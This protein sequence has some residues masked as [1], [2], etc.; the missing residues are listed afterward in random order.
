MQDAEDVYEYSSDS[1]VPEYLLWR[2]HTSL[3]ESRRYVHL[4]KKYYA[5]KEFFDWALEHKESGKM[6]GTCGFSRID[7]TNSCAE[8]GYV[9]NRD[10]W[11][12]GLAVEAAREVIRIGFEILSFNRIEARYMVENQASAR[13]L[14]KLG[15]TFEGV[16][17]KSIFV[18]GQFR[19]IGYYA[20]LKE[21]YSSKKIGVEDT[22]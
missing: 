7:E 21:D 19:D 2:P 10:Y 17:R 18:K 14:A 3:E 1:L 5:K 11:G 15:F 8:L 9:L 6:I 12:Q 22:L 20:L 13:V 4:V 16:H